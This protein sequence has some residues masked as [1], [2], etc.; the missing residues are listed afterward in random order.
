[1][2]N[3]KQFS[4][5]IPTTNTDGTPI[6]AGEI[7]GFVIG[8][9]PSTGVAG[10]YTQTVTVSSP[11]ATTYPVSSVTLAAGSYAAA[12]QVIGPNDSAWSA[13]STF[14]ITET[15]NAPTGFTVA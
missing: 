8:I 10:T 15:P 13:E 7:T 11:T 4:W 9:R 6:A 12:V 3:P 14:T 5:V 1:M 2:S